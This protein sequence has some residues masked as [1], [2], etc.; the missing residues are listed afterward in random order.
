MSMDLISLNVGR[1]YLRYE[2][3][4]CG[5][6]KCVSDKELPMTYPLEQIIALSHVNTHLA[7]KLADIGYANW[8]DHVRMGGQFATAFADQFKGVTPGTIP[9]IKS[10]TI[11]GRFDDLIQ[12]RTAAVANTKAAWD[13]WQSCC[14]K[15]MST[16]SASKDQVDKIPR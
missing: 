4:R 1:V 12:K 2:S 15:V 11:S 3:S 16:P 8:E 10:E 7:R 13:E 9:T 6:L 5:P 14:A